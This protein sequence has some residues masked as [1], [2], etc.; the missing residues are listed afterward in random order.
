MGAEGDQAEVAVLQGGRGVEEGRDLVD[1]F[2]V[3][4]CHSAI[5]HPFTAFLIQMS[6]MA[7]TDA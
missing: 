7:A 2:L 4:A 1:Q 5:L 3:I 6:E